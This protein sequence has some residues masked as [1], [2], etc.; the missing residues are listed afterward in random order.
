MT[1]TTTT[2]KHAIAGSG[3]SLL[4]NLLNK[5]THHL[6]HRR[7]HAALANLDDPMLRDIGLSRAEVEKIFHRR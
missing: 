1:T 4:S 7:A 3:S 2:F 5:I 6:V